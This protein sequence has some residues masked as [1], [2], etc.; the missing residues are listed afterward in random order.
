MIIQIVDLGILL[1]KKK[2]KIMHNSRSSNQNSKKT[3]KTKT[4]SNGKRKEKYFLT[5]FQDFDL[6]LFQNS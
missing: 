2:L 6:Y 1:F 4:K 5:S 3:A